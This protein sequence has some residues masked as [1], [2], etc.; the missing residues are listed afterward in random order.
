MFFRTLLTP[1]FI[2]KKN[3]IILQDKKNFQGLLFQTTQ[4]FFK[5]NKIE[6]ILINKLKQLNFLLLFLSIKNG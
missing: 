3:N 2:D 1:F 5:I 4:K 6:F